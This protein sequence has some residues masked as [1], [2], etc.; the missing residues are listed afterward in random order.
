M[1]ESTILAGLVLVSTAI[2]GALV[3][4]ALRRPE[5]VIVYNE[6]PARP[7]FETQ[8]WGY[9]W[10]PFW[11]KYNGLPGLASKPVKPV[12]PAPPKP[13]IIPKL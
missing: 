5:R 13:I 4:I 3:Y 9:G 10:R 6:M 2:I 11:R 1:G 7:S 8:W 12:I